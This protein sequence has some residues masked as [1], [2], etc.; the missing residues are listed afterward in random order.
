MTS[1]EN[2]E[3]DVPRDSTIVLSVQS[4]S[5]ITSVEMYVGGALVTP[6]V[7]TVAGG[8]TVTYDPGGIKWRYRESVLVELLVYD[9][10]GNYTYFAGSFITEDSD[11]SLYKLARGDGWSWDELRLVPDSHM[12]HPGIPRVTDA[13]MMDT[14][15]FVSG[16]HTSYTKPGINSDLDLRPG[17]VVDFGS[18][19]EPKW[20]LPLTSGDVFMCDFERFHM[21]SN[22]LVAQYFDPREHYGITTVDLNFIPKDMTPIFIGAFERTYGRFRVAFSLER[23]AEFSG[24]N[25]TDSTMKCVYDKGYCSIL[26]TDNTAENMS[27]WYENNCRSEQCP[28]RTVRSAAEYVVWSDVELDGWEFIYDIDTN[29]VVINGTTLIDGLSEVVGTTI[30]YSQQRVSTTYFPIASDARVLIGGT[31][32]TGQCEIDTSSGTIVID[33]T[34]FTTGEDI[35]VTYTVCMLIQYEAVGT[36]DTLASPNL[37]P[38]YTGTDRGFLVVSD[39]D[40]TPYAIRPDVDRDVVDTYSSPELGHDIDVYGPVYIGGDMVPVS[41]SVEGERSSHPCPHVKLRISSFGATGMGKHGSLGTIDGKLLSS[42][43]IWVKA[44]SSGIAR[45]SYVAPYAVSDIC[46]TIK[47]TLPYVGSDYVCLPTPVSYDSLFDSNG[48]SNVYIFAVRSDD[49][50]LGKKYDND[51]DIKAAKERGETVWEEW[52]SPGTDSYGCNGRLELIATTDSSVGCEPVRPSSYLQPDGLTAAT[53]GD[54]VQYLYFPTTLPT[55]CEAFVLNIPKTIVI[56]VT[57]EDNMPYTAFGFQ[58]QLPQHM[59]G[60]FMLG[61][62]DYI[63]AKSFDGIAYFTLNP[64]AQA[65]TD[66]KYDTRSVSGVF[67][68]VSSGNGLLRSRFGVKATYPGSVIYV[69]D[70]VTPNMYYPFAVRCKFRV[71]TMLESLVRNKF[72]VTLNNESNVRCKFCVVEVGTTSVGVSADIVEELSTSTLL[73][74][75]ALI[76]RETAPRET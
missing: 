35:M 59:T 55:D 24:A 50:L 29:S 33:T 56:T 8:V 23:V 16:I 60:E 69:G 47:R 14:D 39:W 54:L 32:V 7:R 61:G 74:I 5:S 2:G 31:D 34:G 66:T 46:I 62:L 48:N 65:I 17:D 67:H 42:D 44:D 27:N 22:G 19:V 68:V 36:Q 10:T 25:G 75:D 30:G 28:H 37:H 20:I 64:F 4:G 53:S 3:R 51:A 1:P 18:P 57:T 73:E 12:T 41:L 11:Y 70:N 58:L 45:F 43:D 6:T 72:V 15:E 71:N 9:Y 49:T 21:Y 13:N 63:G 40:T 26:D 38:V 52:G 76:P